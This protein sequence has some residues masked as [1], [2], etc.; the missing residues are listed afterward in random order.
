MHLPSWTW[1]WMWQI[2]LR[3]SRLDLDVDRLSV[4]ERWQVVSYTIP[5]GIRS[6]YA[7]PVRLWIL[8]RLPRWIAI[9]RMEAVGHDWYRIPTYPAVEHCRLRFGVHGIEEGDL[10]RIEGSRVVAMAREGRNFCEII[11]YLP[12]GE[13]EDDVVPLVLRRAWLCYRSGL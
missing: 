12:S 13:V 1:S 7:R 9:I 5:A 10:L 3:W 6:Y 4:A 8:A 2:F 11:R